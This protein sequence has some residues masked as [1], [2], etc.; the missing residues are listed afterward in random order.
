MTFYTGMVYPICQKFF[1]WASFL[2]CFLLYG[3]YI[4]KTDLFF[5]CHFPYHLHPLKDRR[6][7]LAILIEHYIWQISIWRKENN[8]RICFV[9]YPDYNF[10]K[11]S[12]YS[13]ASPSCS[14]Q[15][16]EP[17]IKTISGWYLITSLCPS[18]HLHKIIP[19]NPC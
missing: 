16:S 12:L 17:L 14:S 15:F 2:P 5:L 4:Y 8:I 18:C 6:L 1:P 7:F 9:F 10:L 19:C 13:P 11:I 3:I